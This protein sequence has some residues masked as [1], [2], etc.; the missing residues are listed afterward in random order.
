MPVPGVPQIAFIDIETA[1]IKAY[2]WQMFETNLLH[3]IE[4]T[5]LLSYAIKR[6]GQKQVTTRA[7]CDYPGYASNMT[8]D[9][10]LLGDL[11]HDLDEHDIFIAHNGDSFDFKKINARLVALGYPPPRPYKTIDTLKIARR[12]F[13]FDSNKLDNLGRYLGVGR[14]VPHTGKDLW[15]G[16]MAGDAKSWRTMKRYN[17][18]DV[19]LLEDVYEKLKPWASAHPDL[20]A[21]SGVCGCPVCQS[22]HVTRK[23]FKINRTRKVQQFQCQECAHWFSRPLT[24]VLHS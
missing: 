9:H 23:G 4:P 21:Y 10:A 7:L 8:S 16:C 12:H 15:L 2:A 14:K 3:V 13:K 17:A 19:T 18:G 6:P 1:P 22:R 20:T 24:H 5:Y 11:W